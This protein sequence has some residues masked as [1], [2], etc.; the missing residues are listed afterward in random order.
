[1]D[2]T[3]VEH[4]LALRERASGAFLAAFLHGVRGQSSAEAHTSKPSVFKKSLKSSLRL[5]VPA[6]IC[7][8]KQPD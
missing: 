4:L 8:S 2:A 3:E 1:M 7:S 5:S 6:A